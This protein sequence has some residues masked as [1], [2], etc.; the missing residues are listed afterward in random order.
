M[1]GDS[2]DFCTADVTTRYDAIDPQVEGV[3]D[4]VAAIDKHVSRRPV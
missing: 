2:V 3:V 4:R 1:E